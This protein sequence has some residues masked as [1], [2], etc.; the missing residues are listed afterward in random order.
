VGYT[1]FLFANKNIATHTKTTISLVILLASPKSPA[2]KT[3]TLEIKAANVEYAIQSNN[4]NIF[5][6]SSILSENNTPKF[7]DN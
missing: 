6:F 5:E 4:L 2:G 3:T 1:R 7:L